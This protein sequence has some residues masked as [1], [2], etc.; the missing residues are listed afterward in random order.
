MKGTEVG[1]ETRGRKEGERKVYPA[2]TSIA[3]V[4][5][6]IKKSELEGFAE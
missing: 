6:S 4:Y 2:A 3:A 5:F 1:Q